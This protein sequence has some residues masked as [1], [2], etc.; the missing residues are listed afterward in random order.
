MKADLED[1]LGVYIY[2]HNRVKTKEKT[3]GGGVAV[4]LNRQKFGQARV[5]A[6][7]THN[8]VEILAVQTDIERQKIVIIAIYCPPRKRPK[9]KVL[10]EV[11]KIIGEVRQRWGAIPVIALGDLNNANFDLKSKFSFMDKEVSPITRRGAALDKIVLSTQLEICATGTMPPLQSDDGKTRSDH[12][13]MYCVVE[14]KFIYHEKRLQTHGWKYK[15]NAQ[16]LVDEY[17]QREDAWESLKETTDVEQ[18]VQAFESTMTALRDIVAVPIKYKKK[19]KDKVWMTK[20]L[21]KE[22]DI[23]NN[24]FKNSGYSDHFKRKRKEVEAMVKKAKSTYYGRKL[25]ELKKSN[26]RQFYQVVRS[27]N[28]PDNTDR[29]DLTEATGEEDQQ[30]AIQKLEEYFAS[31]SKGY[32]KYKWYP[33]EQT[34]AQFQPINEEE[35]QNAIKLTKVAGNGVI[36][37]VDS[38]LLKLAKK[39]LVRPILLIMTR[40]YE[41]N[42]WPKA[43][44]VETGKPVPKSMKPQSIKDLRLVSMTPFVSKVCEQIVIKRSEGEWKSKANRNQFGGKKGT[45]TCHALAVAVQ[46]C[47]DLKAA[48]C[49]L[50]SRRHS[51]RATRKI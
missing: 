32:E 34:S 48:W 37:D 26:T 24:I 5:I 27:M 45:G 19:V 25:D 35:V 43:F 17:L 12:L 51:T 21:K 8:E 29:F 31:L 46:A 4:L 38:G 30:K 42:T 50:T 3:R 10:G 1:K 18:V 2:V 14:L 20:T 16:Q 41:S 7:Q 33:D 49:S 36:N 9:D 15:S 39:H 22:I 44:K 28:D 47:V 11:V 40:M 13:V 6:S 23:K